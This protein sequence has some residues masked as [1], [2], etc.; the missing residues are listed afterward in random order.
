[1]RQPVARVIRSSV[2]PIEKITPSLSRKIKSW[3]WVWQPVHS[4]AAFSALY[5]RS[6]DP[7]NFGSN[8]YEADKYEHSMKLLKGRLYDS[9]LEI[10]ASEG[11]FTRMI[12]PLCK[13]LVAIDVARTAVERASVRLA[14][15][16]HVSIR[17][18][19]VPHQFPEGNFDLIIASDVL[20]Y[21][22]KDVLLDISHQI[23]DKLS[24]GGIFFILHYLGDIGQPLSGGEVHHLLKCHS[25]LDVVHDET[26]ADV[27]PKDAGYTVTIFKKTR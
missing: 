17:Q 16:D 25:D 19:S 23:A 9:A 26:V 21:V 18:A 6:V 10:G 5:D 1:M 8:P 14:D 13:S 2:R 11:I 3:G 12:A 20:Y 24:L 15:L 22:P 27:G 4:P 7:Y